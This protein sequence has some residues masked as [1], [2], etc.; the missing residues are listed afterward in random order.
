MWWPMAFCCRREPEGM[1]KTADGRAFR[2][3][4]AVATVAASRVRSVAPADAVVIGNMTAVIVT[5]AAPRMVMPLRLGECGLIGRHQAYPRAAR[6]T[7]CS[8]FVTK[9]A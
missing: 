7:D 9:R 1:L 3:W 2:A 4:A 6:I 8:A 5:A